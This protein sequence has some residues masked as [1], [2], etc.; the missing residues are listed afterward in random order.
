MID[1]R[2][3][4][5]IVA[6]AAL[7]TQLTS[8]VAIAQQEQPTIGFFIAGLT[9]GQ[10]VPPVETEAQGGAVFALHEDGEAV[11]Y[12][13]AVQGIEN[14]NQAHIHQGAPGENGPIVAWLYPGPATQESLLIS[15][16]KDG[17]LA[18]GT[19]EADDLTGPLEGESLDALV[20]AMAD[21]DA[22]V[23]VH[24]EQNPQG[25][26]RGQIV[27]VTEMVES[28]GLQPEETETPE[29]TGTPEETETG[30]PEA[31]E[32]EEPDPIETETPEATETET[33]EETE[34]E[35]AAE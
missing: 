31:T 33:P 34:T 32:T 15:G 24:T 29:E 13:L 3:T 25:E 17:V 18:D 19:I 23:N 1:R 20:S 5:K 26:I 12:S 7:G 21:G 9:G 16:R 28:L 30:T 6:G 35:T 14:V 8:S 27:T 22:Y 4:L 2:D 11:D 10:Q